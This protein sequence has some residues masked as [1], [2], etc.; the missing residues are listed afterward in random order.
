MLLMSVII[1][2]A[3][4]FNATVH[5][6]SNRKNA[7]SVILYISAI[8]VIYCDRFGVRIQSKITSKADDN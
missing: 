7:T 6:A 3:Y 1:S 8:I 4:R 5:P 2:H